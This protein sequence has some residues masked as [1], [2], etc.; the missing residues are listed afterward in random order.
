MLQT[1]FEGPSRLSALAF[2][3]VKR[4]G[5]ACVR[6][7]MVF[8]ADEL[9]PAKHKLLGSAKA[10]VEVG[11]RYEAL[12]GKNIEDVE[13]PQ[14]TVQLT[15]AIK[16]PSRNRTKATRRSSKS[17]IDETSTFRSLGASREVSSKSRRLKFCEDF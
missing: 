1:L 13:E 2:A 3:T 14:L 17:L 4:R 9:Q 7:D 10:A 11:N 8:S 12:A 15:D 6:G 16:P 5:G